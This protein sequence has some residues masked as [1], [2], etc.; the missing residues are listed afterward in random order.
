MAVDNGKEE[1]PGGVGKAG[2]L[3]SDHWVHILPLLHV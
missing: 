2:A 1:G 3:T